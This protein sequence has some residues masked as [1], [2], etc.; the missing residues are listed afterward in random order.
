MTVRIEIT[1]YSGLVTPPTVVVPQPERVQLRISSQ[2][3]QFKPT[4]RLVR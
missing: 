3:G 1:A 4:L 2:G